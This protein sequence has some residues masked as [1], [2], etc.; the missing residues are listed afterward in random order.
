MKYDYSNLIVELKEAKSKGVEEVQVLKS[1][2]NDVLIITKWYYSDDEM[3][4][5]NY[6][7]MF[8]SIDDEQDKNEIMEEYN[9]EKE[10]LITMN[11][12]DVIKEVSNKL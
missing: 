6:P 2:V 9:N 4:E 8:D 11:I 7:C 12:D 5:M 3:Y 1:F 10:N